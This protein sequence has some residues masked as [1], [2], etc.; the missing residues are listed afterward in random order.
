VSVW[1]PAIT[2]DHTQTLG[3]CE[4]CHDGVTATGKHPLHIASSN[5]CGDCHNT[6]A[7]TPAVFDHADVVP[8]TCATCHDG[9]T[10]T[11]KSAGHIATSASCD[12]CHTTL[13]WVPAGF[14]HSG[15]VPGTCA[16]CHNGT[17]ATG[18]PAGH[19]GTAA[20]C[21]DCHSTEF[22]TPDLFTHTSPF[23]PGDHAGNLPC[24]ACHTS[25]TEV[26]TWTTP[27]YAPDC[28][29]C[30]ANDF[31]PGPHKKHENPDVSYSVAELTDCTGACHTYT[32]SSLTTIKDFRPGP[33]HRVNSGDW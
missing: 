22:W 16:A 13:A 26:V 24:T 4:S 9:L 3:S 8:G 10:A 33:E 27:A 12:L 30:H 29:G 17:T 18:M 2:V 23:Y 14:D 28:A 20:S 6:G 21:D 15:V 5:Q 25:N 32:D 11:G 31:R 7:W 1:T 19:F